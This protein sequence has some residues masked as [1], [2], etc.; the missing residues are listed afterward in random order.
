LK[1]LRYLKPEWKAALMIFVLLIAQALCE[2]ALPRYTSVLVDVG[3]QQYGIDSAAAEQLGQDTFDALML[4]MEEDEAALAADAYR[5]EDGVYILHQKDSGTLQALGAAFELPMAVLYGA[6]QMPGAQASPDRLTK[7]LASG[8]VN[9]ETLL[10]QVEQM[11]AAQGGGERSMLKQTAVR[12]VKEEYD[13]LGLD[14]GRI[15]RSYLVAAGGRMLAVTLLMGATM[16]VSGFVSGRTS[17]RIGRR[18]RGRLFDK[19]LAFSTAEINRF[20]TA[21]LITRSTNDVQ[22]VQQAS[23]MLL[24]MVLYAPI[25]GIG[26]ILR[27]L[28]TRSGIGWIVVVAVASMSAMVLL[29]STIAIPKFK[30]LQKQTDRLNLVSR[31]ILTGV[32]VVRAFTREAYEEQRFEEANRTLAGTN[33]FIGRT[34]SLLMPTMMLIMNIIVLMIIW[35]GA[36]GVDLGTMQ[37]GTMIAFIS[38]TMQVVMAFM[39]VSMSAMFLP[40]AGVASDRIEEVLNT[41]LTV[42]DKPAGQDLPA[43]WHGRV[44]FEGVTFRY[45]DAEQDVLHVVSFEALPGQTTAIIGG[46]GSGKSSII[47]MIP[48]FFDVTGGRVT[49][50]GIDVRDIPLK[51]LRSLIGFVPQKGVLFKGD[52]RSNIKFADKDMPDEAMEEAARIAQAEAFILDKEEGYDSSIAQ[53][54]DNV[55]GGQK[56][57]LSIA[58]AIAA[59]PKILLFDDSFSALDYRTDLALRRAL[60]RSRRDVTVI[61]VAQRIATVMHADRIIVLDNGAV[62]GA[63]THAE[64]LRTSSVYREI[65]Q[66]QLTADELAGK[67]GEGA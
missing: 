32:S 20:S 38:Y 28:E 30:A 29:F 50:D 59:K 42:E 33:R 16:V 22:Q 63:G 7:A 1:I 41:P 4:L 49:V 23:M 51:T 56:Q 65:A 37:V 35:F 48:R 40:R 61:V 17:A 26:G 44:R 43:V 11:L 24:R 57:R 31:E 27:V 52:I 39:M 8:V 25:L 3:V 15:Q 46:T 55:S 2:L 6:A 13:R 67:A 45:P 47:H 18:L 66:S 19:V 12:F 14:T 53:G 58:R 21:S 54:G 10:A 64:L 5:L 36:R 34:F 9:R 62:V 60:A